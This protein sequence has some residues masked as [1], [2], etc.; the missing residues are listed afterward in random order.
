MAPGVAAEGV[1]LCDAGLP[2]V[3]PGWIE[4][5]VAAQGFLLGDKEARLDLVPCENFGDRFGM[6]HVAGVQGQVERALAGRV[7]PVGEAG[8]GAQDDGKRGAQCAAGGR[9]DYC[10]AAWLMKET[11]W[12]ERPTGMEWESFFCS[13]LTT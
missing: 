4:R 9:H 1:A 6:P 13:R 12:G 2:V 5:H 3:S 11:P 8:C 10:L 7:S